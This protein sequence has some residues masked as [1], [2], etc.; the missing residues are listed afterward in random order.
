MLSLL[1]FYSLNPGGDA[2]PLPGGRNDGGGPKP[3]GLACG[4]IIGGR[5][6]KGIGLYLTGG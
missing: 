5:G 6:G 4:G 1:L 3:G 2:L